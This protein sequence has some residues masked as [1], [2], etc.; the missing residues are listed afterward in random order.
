MVTREK[1]IFLEHGRNFVAAS[2]GI[3]FTNYIILFDFK[4]IWKQWK[5]IQENFPKEF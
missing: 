3:E 1:E 5:N 2:F 4:R